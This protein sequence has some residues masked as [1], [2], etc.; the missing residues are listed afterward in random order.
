MALRRDRRTGSLLDLL[1]PGLR[2]GAE[3]WGDEEAMGEWW[4]RRKEWLLANDFTVL[5]LLRAERPAAAPSKRKPIRSA[6][7][8]RPPPERRKSR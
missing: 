4:A 2:S 8:D 6:P 7:A 3:P 1:P 5:A